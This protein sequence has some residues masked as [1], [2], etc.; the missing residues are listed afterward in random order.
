MKNKL[1]L[2]TMMTLLAAHS[3][4]LS[5]QP[6]ATDKRPNFII[7]LA[8][9]LGYGDIG[10]YGST[11]IKTP[12]IDKLA[13]QGI[14]LNSFYASANV[15]TASRGGLL[16]GRYPIRLNLVA[17]VIYGYLDPKVKLN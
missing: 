11:L 7:I 17:D 8:D 2:L 13:A 6:A 1:V 10:S 12:N 14:Q 16:T 15:C 5:A 3:A 4:L 9:D